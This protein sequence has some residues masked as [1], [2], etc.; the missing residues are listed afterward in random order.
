MQQHD[1]RPVPAAADAQLDIVKS[2]SLKHEPIKHRPNLP[3]AA[4]R[5]PRRP[6][7]HRL[8]RTLPQSLA[9]AT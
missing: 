8:E 2:H 4:I 1:R 9:L 3:S 5:G 7:D 6:R